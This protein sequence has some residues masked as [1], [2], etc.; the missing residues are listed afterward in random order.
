M[1]VETELFGLKNR[2]D[3]KE[4]RVIERADGSIAVLAGEKVLV[5]SGVT[6]VT[7]VPS[8]SGLEEFA[9][10]ARL[11]P[12][13][14]L[15]PA[16]AAASAMASGRVAVPDESLMIV[17]GG[18]MD[19]TLMRKTAVPAGSKGRVTTSGTKLLEGGVEVRFNVV[20]WAPDTVFIPVPSSKDLITAGAENLARQGYNAIRIHGIEHFLMSGVAGAAKFDADKLDRF[21]FFLSELKRVG[22][23]WVINVMSYNLFVDM[24][25]A[26][27][28]F[29]YTADTSTK[30]RMYTEQNVRENWLA[31]MSALLNRVN[32][33]TGIAIV[34]DPALLMIAVYNEQS[35]TF[36]AANAFPEIWK[37]RT[38]GSV[39]AAQTWGEWLSDPT[40]SHGYANLSALN[41]GWGSAHA[42]FSAA[43]AA[44]VPKFD[45]TFP[46]TRQAID[47]VKYAMYLEDDMAAWYQSAL[48]ALGYSGIRFWS[49]IYHALLEARGYGKYAALN[50]VVGPH[51]YTTVIDKGINDGST[52]KTGNNG[53]IWEYEN[54]A[55]M[56]T[57]LAN[58]RPLIA[59]E[60]GWPAWCK[61]MAHFPV[62][63]AMARSHDCQYVTHYAQGDFFAQT[64][65]ND[66][67]LHGDRLRRIEPYNNPGNPTQDFVRVALNAIYLRG[68]VSP[69]DVS[70]RKSLI[71]NERHIGTN[72]V[73]TGRAYRSMFTLLQPLY[74][75][76][77]FRRA[78]VDWTDDTTDDTLASVETPK[79][80]RTLIDEAISDGAISAGHPTAASVLINSGNIA[81]VTLSGVVG[82]LTATGTAPVFE[83]TG[84]TLAVGDVLFISN[85]TGAT[86]TWPGTSIRNNPQVVTAKS[87]NYVQISLN[88]SAASG[89]ISAGT[90]SE[91]LNVAYNS[92]QEVFWSRRS[93]TAGI[94]T[95]R[96]VLF[97]HTGATLPVTLGNVRIDALTADASMLVTTLDGLPIGQSRKLLLMLAGDSQNSGMQFTD[98]TRKT[99]AA[100]G[101]GEYPI[102]ASDVSAT[103]RITQSA[104]GHPR[105]T[106]VD[107]AG[108]SK[109]APR[110]ALVDATGFVVSV[111]TADSLCWQWLIEI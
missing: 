93:K 70:K 76:A 11:L 31:G 101:G 85:L 82:G 41:T 66:T 23:Y 49:E 67:S 26:T 12:R 80:L 29:P 77:A 104:Y 69:M 65:Y 109:S 107:R 30:P 110:H 21:D 54:S 32:P 18:P 89:A 81:S 74:F 57:M 16:P 14:G 1:G 6:P 19:H 64:Y 62:L 37:T 22:I 40:K 83:L 79:S 15:L 72:P 10:G 3:G 96:T 4:F 45:V 56:P 88:L 71:L 44:A 58:N 36:C 25:G 38:A 61:Y 28:R 5:D 9:S 99:I 100:G 2:G 7:A 97:S 48:T 105:V 59:A 51:C 106:P 39:A 111:R 91:G 60:Y 103:I 73:A 75:M 43:A 87:G 33:Y 98:A 86:G 94:N 52:Q 8:G 42:S 46:N 78:G 84:N 35:T 63:A 50:Q 90:W 102:Q 17:P 55:L 13:A 20:T 47:A 108:I 24:Q 68:D 34:T 53:P 92:T 95:A 27:N